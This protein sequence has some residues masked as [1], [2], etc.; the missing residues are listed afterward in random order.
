MKVICEEQTFRE[1]S[2]PLILSQSDD[3][4]HPIEDPNYIEWWYFD[5]MNTDGSL[6][7]G[8]FYIAGDVSRQRKVRTG[9]RA[10]YVRPDGMEL[11]IDEKFPYSSFKRNEHTLIMNC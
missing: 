6:I 7:R 9:V 5:M 1:L 3:A 2:E 11:L 10:S 4:W 8:Q